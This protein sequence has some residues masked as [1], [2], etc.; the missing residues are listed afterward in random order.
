ML[1]FLSTDNEE[2][3]FGMDFLNE[4]QLSQKNGMSAT[5][6][7]KDWL[8]FSC[9]SMLNIVPIVGTLV[10]L[11]MLIYLAVSR[12]TAES[13]RGFLRASFILALV[14]LALYVI[15]FVVLFSYVGF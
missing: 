10:Y 9:L 3:V 1:E 11:G 2:D 8:K 15:L 12:D 13:V 4:Y 5:V 7:T 6:S 14:A